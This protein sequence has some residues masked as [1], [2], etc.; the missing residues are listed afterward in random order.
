[1]VA[2]TKPANDKGKANKQQVKPALRLPA[3]RYRIYL[4]DTTKS[5]KSNEYHQKMKSSCFLLLLTEFCLLLSVSSFAQYKDQTKIDSLL[6]ELPKAKEDT[7][8]VNLLSNIISEYGFSNDDKGLQYE[9]QAV[10]LA[11]KLNFR[12]G[13]ASIKKNIGRIYWRKGNY[14]SALKYHFDALKIYQELNNNTQIAMMYVFIGQDYAGVGKNNEAIRYF[15]IGL[16]QYEKLGDKLNCAD[17]YLLFAFVYE[18]IGNYAEVIKNNYAA[19]RIYES[20]GNQSR[21]AI[22]SN[23][24]AEESITAGNNKEALRLYQI[25]VIAFVESGDKENLSNTYNHIGNVYTKMGNYAKALKYHALGLKTGKENNDLNCIAESNRCIGEVYQ[26][27]SNYNE[28]LKYFLPA[29]EMFTKL[30]NKQKLGLLCS[31]ISMCYTKLKN[32]SEAQNYLVKG[33]KLSLEV[34]YVLGLISSYQGMELLDSSKGNWKSAYF[35]HKYYITERDSIFNVENTKKTVHVEMQYEADK[36]EVAAKAEQEKRDIRQR[37]IRNSITAGLA[38]ALIFLLVVY[39]QRNTINKEKKRSDALLLNILPVKVAEELKEKGSVEAQLIDDA[40]VL[41]TDFKGFTQLTEKLTPKQL[42]AEINECFSAF[43]LIM[44]K[45]GVEKIKTIGDSYMAVGGLPIVNNTHALDIMSAAL[46][47][48]Q[49]MQ[50]HKSK[51]EA[52]GELFFEIRIGVHTGPVIA[53]IVGVN[54]F[55]YDIWGDTVNIASRM[56]SSGEVGKVNI[57]GST[58]ELVKDKFSCI[59]RGKIEA[60]GKGVIEMYFVESVL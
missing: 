44:Q 15:K 40:T 39:R 41:F 31:Q 30:S 56:E 33:Q 9:K 54:K 29:E 36:K 23:N 24:L 37:N 12:S 46:D 20:M 42:V 1:M 16:A 32:F 27:Q 51:K 60:K 35:N 49:F 26:K 13:L 7:N 2:F 57:S 21:I 8:K 58:Y 4:E 55:A 14:E 43:D 25:S 45:H 59:H 47:I 5:T 50:E 34:D 38:G 53:G 52:A 19:L 17:I 22:V 28:A 6:S 10:Q 3:G 18:N 48:Q 11:E